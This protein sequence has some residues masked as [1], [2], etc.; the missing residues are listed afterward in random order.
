MGFDADDDNALL[1]HYQ[2]EE[3]RH[4]LSLLAPVSVFQ[5]STSYELEVHLPIDFVTDQLLYRV[6]TEDGLQIDNL[7][8]ATDFPLLAVNEISEVEFQL[9]NV[10]LPVELELGYHHLALLEVGNEEPL[11]VMHLI[12]TPDVCYQNKQIQKNKK[13]VSTNILCLMLTYES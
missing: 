11:A 3:T 7:L 9:Y 10:T 8:T 1:V 5:Q 12:I 2:E 13:V 4:W 6:T